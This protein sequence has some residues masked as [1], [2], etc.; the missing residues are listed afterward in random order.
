MI[1]PEKLTTTCGDSIWG[2]IWKNRGEYHE[3]IS[4]IAGLVVRMLICATRKSKPG[5]N[6]D[7][8][9]LW[10]VGCGMWDAG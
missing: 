2:P 10:D 1:I 6:R 3:L 5:M 7:M 9:F 4:Q 8:G